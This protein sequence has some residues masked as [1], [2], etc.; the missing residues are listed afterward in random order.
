MSRILAILAVGL[1]A[2]CR[3]L[4][5]PG[6]PVEVSLD[7]ARPRAV[8]SRIETLAH[9]RRAIRG[10]ARM[11]RRNTATD[12]P[13]PLPGLNGFLVLERPARLRFEI[14]GF[15]A[16][17][18]VL[19]SDGRRFEYLDLDEGQREQGRVHASLL[20][21]LVGVP[22]TVSE[23]VHLVIGLP[24][25]QA[26][27][28]LVGAHALPGGGLRLEWGDRTG[29]VVR[30]VE[31]DEEDRLRSIEQRDPRGR[32]QWQARYDR[33][34]LVGEHLLAHQLDV[35]FPPLDTRFE[36]NLRRVEL[37]PE[38]PEATFRLDLPGRVQ[39]PG[40]AGRAAARPQPPARGPRAS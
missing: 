39:R 14:D 7:A 16:T 5:P 6:E 35:D 28:E 19:V 25:P 17:A 24:P 2:G 30:R 1:L 21:R 15:M 34:A 11:R 32:I 37:N 26:W 36:V 38:V 12:L 9:E 18:A 4:Q 3:T 31:V 23:A 33:Y 40:G 27:G 29:R 13:V 10:T 8:L 22:L 20:W